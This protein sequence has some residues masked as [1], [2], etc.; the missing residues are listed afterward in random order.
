[1]PQVV[2]QPSFGNPDAWRHWADTLEQEVHYQGAPHAQALTTAERQALDSL[3]PTGAARF[4]GATGTHDRRMSTLQTGDVVLFTGRKKVRAVGEVG[5]SFRNPAFADTLW[6]PHS[7]RGSYRNVYSLVAFQPTSIN[8]EEIWDLPGFNANDNFMGL[9]FLDD[10]K[11]AVVIDGLGIETFTAGRRDVERDAELATILAAG[12]VVDVEAVNMTSTTYE[13][14][15]ASVLVRRAEALLVSSYRATLESAEVRRLRTPSGVT[16]LYVRSAAG[17]E[18]VEAKRSAGHGFVRQ[19]L[20]QL[21]DYAVHAPD[22]V[23]VLTALFPDR[24]SASDVGLLHRYGID[25]VHRDASGAFVRA[26]ASAGA[27]SRMKALW[28][29]RT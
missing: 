22:E 8:Y 21:L 23:D 26:E 12:L 3:H 19:A 24:P 6:Q 29:S 5:Y 20:G 13:R 11:S 15:G 14:P 4:W 28:S 18:I 17:A 7:D 2:V 9:R 27:R 16:D 10:D 1:M 25:V